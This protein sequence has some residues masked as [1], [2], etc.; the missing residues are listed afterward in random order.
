MTKG[1]ELALSHFII[2]GNEIMLKQAKAI[3]KSDNYD[4]YFK[5]HSSPHFFFDSVEIVS[6]E[7]MR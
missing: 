2:H 7:E 3:R 1:N 5:K 6:C 4:T